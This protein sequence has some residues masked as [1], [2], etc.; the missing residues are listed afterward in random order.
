ME[1]I[2]SGLPIIGFD[3]RYGNQ[4][5]IDHEKN[6]YKIPVHDRMEGSERIQTL[7]DSIIRMFTEADLEAFHKH[8][9]DKAENYLTEE[10]QKRWAILLN[11]TM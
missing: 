7:A 6:G 3:V 5:F 8:S 2:G 9:Y 10:V 1:A 11:Q 4:N